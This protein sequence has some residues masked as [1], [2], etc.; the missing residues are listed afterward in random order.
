MAFL[1]MRGTGN[2]GTDERPKH[3]REGILFLYP[4]G[5]AP[6]TALLS[7]MG[8][9]KI[10]DYDFTWWTKTHPLQGGGVTGVYTNAGLSSAYTSGGVAGTTLYIKMSAATASEIKVTHQVMLRD[11][12]HRDMIVRA[13]VTDVVSN[14]AS[15]Y[16]AVNLQEADDNGGTTDLSD[17]D[18]VR[19]IGSINAQ[20]APM[21]PAIAYDP[22]KFNNLMQIFRTALSITRTARETKLRTVDAYKEAKREALE[23]HSVEMEMA[24]VWGKKTEGVG[25]NGKPKYTTDGIYE[26]LLNNAPANVSNFSTDTTYTGDTW[27]ASGEHWFDTMLELVYRYGGTQRLA[28]MGSGAALGISRLAKSTGQIQLT[29]MTTDYGLNITKWV[30]P[31]GTL[32]MMSAPLFSEDPVTRNDMIIIDPNDLKYNFIHDTDFIPDDGRHGGSRVDGTNEEYLT[33]C[34]LEF[35][36]PTKAAYLQGIGIDNVL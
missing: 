5:R 26:F 27:L 10:D 16:I 25:A 23:L 13:E 3:Y 20:G 24:F 12:S 7:K 34:G 9:K 6:L 28:L 8:S 14:G 18:N 29:P 15:S 32:N 4:N 30:H 31:S 33:E 19:V 35:H 21:P 22:V 1:G 36:H 11:I 2:W 17:C